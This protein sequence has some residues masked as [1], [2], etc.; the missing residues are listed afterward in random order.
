MVGEAPGVLSPHQERLAKGDVTQGEH[1]HFAARGVAA[2][3]IE[4]RDAAADVVLW[5]GGQQPD[6]RSNES[7]APCIAS[8]ADSRSAS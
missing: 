6:V 8:S 1:D 4:D 5:A 3:G 7:P 2:A